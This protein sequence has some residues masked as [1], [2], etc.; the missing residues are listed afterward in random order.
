[1][2]ELPKHKNRKEIPEYNIWK[3]MRARCSA[4][5]NKYMGKYQKL[6]IKVCE[7]WNDFLLF[8]QDMG[9]RPS[10]KYSIDR[11]DPLGDY[12]P[13]NCRWATKKTQCENR[14]EFN[15]VY[16]YGG[17]YKVLKEWARILEIDYSK[18]HK[19]ISYQ[20]M[21]FED[22]INYKGPGMYTLNGICKSIS[23]WADEYG[24]SKGNLSSRL[25]R[26]KTLEEALNTPIKTR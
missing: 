1:M 15:R 25:S 22:A 23:E 2:F 16:E 19:R 12:E 14:G 18:L 13:S 26:G 17:E 8:Y 11:K 4:P 21:T 5:C 24:I 10:N 7:R 6:N 20:G 9:P 3:G